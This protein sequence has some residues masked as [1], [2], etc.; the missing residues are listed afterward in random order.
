MCRSRNRRSGST[1]CRGSAACAGEPPAERSVSG[2]GVQG[3]VDLARFL[4]LANGL[5]LIVPQGRILA[6]AGQGV[7]GLQPWRFA[8][9]GQPQAVVLVPGGGFN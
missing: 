7:P 1:A 9:L 5:A 3:S 4:G 6:L 8:E 2:P